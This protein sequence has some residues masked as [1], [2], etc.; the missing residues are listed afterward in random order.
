MNH[1]FNVPPRLAEALDRYGYVG[2]VSLAREDGEPWTEHDE[3][4]ARALLR[5]HKLLNGE[6]VDRAPL[7]EIS[8]P[9]VSQQMPQ[10]T[11]DADSL[12]R[13]LRGAGYVGHYL[14]GRKDAGP[15]SDKDEIKIRMIMNALVMR[16]ES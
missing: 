11:D 5:T 14:V 10:G 2:Q 8:G 3:S 12:E 1:L 7:V 16:G 4:S 13:V 9:K 6:A 15:M